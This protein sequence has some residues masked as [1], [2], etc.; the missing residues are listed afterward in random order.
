MKPKSTVVFGGG[1][2]IGGHVLQSLHAAGITPVAMDVIGVRSDLGMKVEWVTGSIADTNLVAS[3]AE[4]RDYA[5]FLANASLPGSS[6][7]NMYHEAKGHVAATLRVA[8]ICKDVGVRKLVF[9]SSGG[10]V[11]GH[12]APAEGWLHEDAVTRPRNG[13]GA[14]KLAIEHFLR[15]VGQSGPMKTLSLRLS[16]PYGVGQRATR[17][18][19]VIAAAMQ[20][21]VDGTTMEIWGDGTVERD[22]IYVSDIAQAFVAATAYEGDATEINVGA[23]EATS[24]NQIIEGVRIATGRPLN[25]EYHPSRGIDVRRNVLDIKRAAQELGWR[26]SVSFD[27]GM[28]RTAAWWAEISA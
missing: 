5:I 23:G 28:A 26:P 11:Y 15:L 7:S 25:V 13:Y 24:I 14:S 22:F 4:G 20:H 3:V 1:G 12:D 9:A 18:Q 16:N 8:E 19:G 6:Q 17:A 27:E 10:T 2:F 21:A